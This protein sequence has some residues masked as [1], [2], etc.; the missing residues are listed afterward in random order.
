[1]PNCT[2]I[3]THVFSMKETVCTAHRTAGNNRC[4]RRRPLWNYLDQRTWLGVTRAP[5]DLARPRYSACTTG[6]EA[7]HSRGAHGCCFGGPH[8]LLLSTETKG[9]WGGRRMRRWVVSNSFLLGADKSPRKSG[10]E[11]RSKN[12]RVTMHW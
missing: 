8:F 5:T 12:T 4:K 3:C 1:M 10:N 7:D 6:L 9:S 11:E 2:T